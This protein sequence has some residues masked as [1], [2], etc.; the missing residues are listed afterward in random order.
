MNHVKLWKVFRFSNLPGFY[1]IGFSDEDITR[2]IDRPLLLRIAWFAPTP[3]VSTLFGHLSDIQL[4]KFW[5]FEAKFMEVLVQM[6][7]VFSWVI[8][9]FQPLISRVVSSNIKLHVGKRNFIWEYVSVTGKFSKIP[10]SGAV[11][12]WGVLWH[13]SSQGWKTMVYHFLVRFLQCGP[14][15]VINGVITH[16]NGLITG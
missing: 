10:F 1:L 7:F 12:F 16:I 3:V 9:R 14:L 6:M 13:R 15:L 11:F 2:P 8:F 4:R 5:Y